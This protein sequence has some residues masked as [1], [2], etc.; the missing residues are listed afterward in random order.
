[1]VNKVFSLASFGQFLEGIWR[2]AGS[3]CFLEV[4]DSGKYTR[5]VRKRKSFLLDFQQWRSNASKASSEEDSVEVFPGE[6]ELIPLAKQ[7]LAS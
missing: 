2:T 4:I 7:T 5:F 6:L 3:D 1:M